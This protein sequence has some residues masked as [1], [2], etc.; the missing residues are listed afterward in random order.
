MKSQRSEFGALKLL[1]GGCA[2]VAQT[3]AV[4]RSAF[5]RASN[6]CPG[7]RRCPYRKTALALSIRPAAQPPSA[8]RPAA[9]SPSETVLTVARLRRNAAVRVTTIGATPA[10]GERTAT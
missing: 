7:T 4:A 6:S 8:W 10:P 2:G 3:P 5:G 1:G 9:V